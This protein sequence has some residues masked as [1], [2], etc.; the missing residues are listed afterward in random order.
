MQFEKVENLENVI[1]SEKASI[2]IALEALEKNGLRILIVVDQTSK[3]VGILSDGDIR[4]AFLKK[5]KL[6][7]NVIKF[8]NTKFYYSKVSDINKFEII[9]KD[10][11]IVP[12]LG[13]DRRIITVL[14]RQSVIRTSNLIKDPFLIMA[15]GKGTRLF[16]LTQNV[17]KPLV[18]INDEPMIKLIIDK[19]RASGFRKFI[20]SV[21]YLKEKIIEYLGDGSKLGVDI[22]YLEETR[23]LGTAGALG[24]IQNSNF[25]NL[26]VTNCDVITGSDYQDIYLS[27]LNTNSHA[28][29]VV[30]RFQLQNPYGV[31][32]T[33]ENGLISG[34]TEKPYYESLI[35]AGMYVLSSEVIKLLK[36]DEYL[37]MPSLFLRA[38][39]GGLKC[40]TYEIFEQWVDVG[41]M[42][43][44]ESVRNGSGVK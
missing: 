17:P 43:E 2:A 29:M 6:S 36:R 21:N 39:E 7:S 20:V 31:V 3:V 16:P 38:I 15:G 30:K 4:R 12:I 10:V 13:T 1:I 23:P 18:T 34:F 24:M 25:K 8:M 32:E 28:S 11:D 44:L 35:N 37:D 41:V 14:R 19:A 27:H 5:A 26:F 42:D 40:S 33:T 9:P 22:S